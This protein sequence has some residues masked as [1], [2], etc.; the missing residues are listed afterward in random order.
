[1]KPLNSIHEHSIPDHSIHRSPVT[2]RRPAS[3]RRP[4]PASQR[5]LSLLG[6]IVLG[7]ILVFGA[8]V[9]LKVFP[10]ATEFIAVNRAVTKAR[11]DGTDPQT[12]RASFDRAA[13]ID[14]ITSITGK[15]LQIQ[16]EPGG[17]YQVSFAYEKRIPLFGPASLLLDYR[18][19]A[20]STTKAK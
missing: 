1:L 7:V 10:T 18:G 17:G 3:P 2:R 5:G 8:L 16:R 11:T 15:D 12:I 9:T 20:S 14:D 6:L 4:Y 13:A 19:E